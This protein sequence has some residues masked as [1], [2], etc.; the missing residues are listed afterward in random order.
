MKTKQEKEDLVSGTFTWKIND[1]SKLKDDKL[2]SQDFIIAGLK[3]RIIIN[4]KG[5]EVN[6][7]KHLSIYLGVDATSKWPS[8]W[9]KYAYFSMT[10]VNQFDGNKSVSVPTTGTIRQEFNKDQNEWG[11][12]SFMRL[13]D[14]YDHS[15][16]Y[17]VNDICI[18][19]AKVDVPVMF[20]VPSM[21]DVPI[22]IESQGDDL[23]AIRESLKIPQE[24]SNVNSV[25]YPASSAAPEA[26]RSEMLPS[27][28]GTLALGSEQVGLKL[29]H[30]RCAVPSLVKEHGEVPTIPTGE[31]INFRGLGLIEKAFVPL[32][33]EVC[34]WHPSLIESQH[35]K[36]RMFTECAFTALGRLLHFLQTTKV[37][38]MTEDACGQLRLFWEELETF[39]FGLAWLEPQVHSAYDKKKFVERAGRVKRL[40]EDVECLENETKRR[41]AMLTVTELDLQL[42]KR[43]LAKAE[44]GFNEIEMDCKLGYGRC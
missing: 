16:G 2:Y 22:K 39:K 17:L 9:S 35:N 11:V 25:Q 23:Y 4:P 13:S 18:I 33:E 40:K 15:A 24:P 5:N 38:D 8:G 28:Q 32:L 3:W 20:D 34:S 21:V 36:S 30:G 12:K 7:V 27:F 26:P 31:L 1:F 41:K 14:L 44:E 37:K 43:D 6:L 19:Q 42:A 29:N 10:V